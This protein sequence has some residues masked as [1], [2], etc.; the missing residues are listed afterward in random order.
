MPH[1]AH[2]RQGHVRLEAAWVRVEADGARGTLVGTIQRGERLARLYA[3]P[4]HARLAPTEG[5]DALDGDRKRLGVNLRQQSSE[6]VGR[7]VIDVADEAQ[8]DVHVVRID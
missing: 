7:A 2:A 1:T 3:R 5:A 6:L 8:R 4:Q